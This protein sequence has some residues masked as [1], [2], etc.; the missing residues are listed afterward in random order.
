MSLPYN[1]NGNV[2]FLVRKEGVKNNDYDERIIR[3]FI[4]QETTPEEREEMQNLTFLTISELIK[5]KIRHDK[6]KRPPRIQNAFVIFR[7]DY[8]AWIASE[9]PYLTS[10]FRDISIKSSALWHEAS[11]D[12]KNCFNKISKLAKRF[13]EKIWSGNLYKLRSPNTTSNVSASRGC[14]FD[15]SLPP[16][17]ESSYHPMNEQEN[18]VNARIN[19]LKVYRKTLEINPSLEFFNKYCKDVL[20]SLDKNICL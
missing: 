15:N 8:Q 9:F 5:P 12:K 11:E 16:I 20:N 18:Q 10:E 1:K 19:N 13:H 3:E 4:L 7:K 17:F 2:I 14:T 6:D